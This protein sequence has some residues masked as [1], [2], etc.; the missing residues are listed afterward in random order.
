M[1][2]N[3]LNINISVGYC[4]VYG[5]VG[6]CVGGSLGGGSVGNWSVVGGQMVGGFNKTHIFSN[7]LDKSKATVSPSSAFFLF[8]K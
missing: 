8:A 4:W 2:S 7:F 6:R 5:W 1:F 3:L